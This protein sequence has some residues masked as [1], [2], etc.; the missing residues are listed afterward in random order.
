MQRNGRSTCGNFL[1]SVAFM[2]WKRLLNSGYGQKRTTS[3][4]HFS[5][6][7]RATV[8]CT[9]MMFYPTDCKKMTASSLGPDL[10][11]SLRLWKLKSV[12]EKP[13]QHSNGQQQHRQHSTSQEAG[14]TAEDGSQH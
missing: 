2:R 1:S 5:W 7:P 14:R 8:E 12:S 9:V 10:P 3:R 4:K 13:T 11:V 6:A